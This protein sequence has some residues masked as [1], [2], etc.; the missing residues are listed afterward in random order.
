VQYGDMDRP[1]KL[2]GMLVKKPALLRWLSPL[3]AS[4]IRS[5]FT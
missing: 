1:G 3:L 4:G 5:L 2:V